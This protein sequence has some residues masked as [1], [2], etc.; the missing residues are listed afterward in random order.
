MTAL[1]RQLS[2]QRLGAGRWRVELAL[3][4]DPDDPGAGPHPHP[5]RVAVQSAG[6]SGVAGAEIEALSLATPGRGRFS[7]V[8][9]VRGAARGGPAPRF[10]LRG[11]GWRGAVE[12]TADDEPAPPRPRAALPVPSAVDYTARDFDAL[13]TMLLGVL[14]ERF[15]PGLADHPVAQ[16]SAL[17]EQLAYLGDALSYRQDAVATEAYLASA[18]RRISVTRHAALLDYPVFTGRSA[19]AWVAFDVSAPVALPAG[20]RLLAQAAGQG[21]WQ[22]AA[23]AV[24]FIFETLA[25]VELAPRGRPYELSPAKHP[26]GRL[27]ASSTTATLSGDC[28][29]LAAGML[30][31]LAAVGTDPLRSGQVIRLSAVDRDGAATTTITWDVED[32][33]ADDWELTQHPLCVHPANLVLADHG[34]AHEWTALPEPEPSG[35]YWPLLPFAGPAYSAGATGGAGASAAAMLSASG[36]PAPAAVRLREGGPTLWREWRQRDS[37]LESS[38]LDPGFVVE[39]D[40]G[41]VARLRFGDGTNGM[42][43]SPGTRFEVWMRAGGGSA[44]NV[45]AGTISRLLG[46]EA[47]VLRVG[48]PMRAVGGADPEPLPAVRV[49]APRAFRRTDRAVTAPEYSAAAL[50]VPG[51]ADATTMIVASGSGPLARVRIHA[52]DWTVPVGP[53]VARVQAALA[54]RRPVGVAIDVRG[55]VPIPATIELVVSVSSGWSLAGLSSAIEAA[56]RDSLLAPRRFGF[57]TTLHRSDLVKL[58]GA[59]AGVGDVRVMWFEWTGWEGSRGREALLP[60][61]GHVIR[62]D[63]DETEP[64]NGSVSFRLRVAS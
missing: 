45:G 35:R 46:D 29:A 58:L 23:E 4:I 61:F 18:R 49:N 14:N 56:L 48:N 39:L 12:L 47:R 13:R 40:D 9:A 10:E 41:G 51:V 24:G 3:P 57:G 55:A 43:P 54:A 37:L 15:G 17:V 20:T 36:R 2:A 33:L 62:I 53:L 50:A 16:T 64:A 8:L 27:V 19:R 22:P 21:T 59:I 26:G 31:T 28:R 63:N 30:I 7:V 6:A 52:G 44:A 5:D 42:Q 25:P 38:A 1:A 11:D 60:P 34:Q 32:A